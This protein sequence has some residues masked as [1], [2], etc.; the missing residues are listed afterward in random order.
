[1]FK[2]Y[3]SASV[4][5]ID[6]AKKD[7]GKIMKAVLVEKHIAIKTNHNTRYSV[8]CKNGL[9][10]L[11]NKLQLSDY[12]RENLFANALRELDSL[13]PAKP[14]GPF[15]EIT[16]SAKRYQISRKQEAVVAGTKNP[17]AFDKKTE[18]GMKQHVA[19]AERVQGSIESQCVEIVSRFDNDLQ[20]FLGKITVLN[21]N[22]SIRLF[23]RSSAIGRFK[24]LRQRFENKNKRSAQ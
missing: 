7:L 12:C 11:E 6:N 16:K 17:Q 9:L 1:M 18:E 20:E 4:Q 13:N 3:E 23:M 24:R 14:N 15:V 21:R 2:P 19:K 10:I 22:S 5:A 8:S